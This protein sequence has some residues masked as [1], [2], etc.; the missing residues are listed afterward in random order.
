[1][2]AGRDERRVTGLE[3]SSYQM[4]LAGVL[5]GSQTVIVNEVFTAFGREITSPLAQ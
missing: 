4:M 1:M 3:V 5:T 2:T